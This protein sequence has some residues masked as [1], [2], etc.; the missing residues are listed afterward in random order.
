MDSEDKLV[1]VD[2]EATEEAETS[3][4]KEL[5][6]LISYIRSSLFEISP[7]EAE[8]DKYLSK[9]QKNIQNEHPEQ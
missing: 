8:K 4:N 9:S 5:N 6:D 3:E 7:N 1:F 2:T